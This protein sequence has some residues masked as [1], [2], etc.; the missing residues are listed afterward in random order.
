MS[1]PLKPCPSCGAPERQLLPPVQPDPGYTLLTAG[2][3]ICLEACPSCGTLWC[4]SPYE[5]Y[6]S[7]SYRVRWP[8]SAATWKQAH[9][10]DN[11][12]TLRHW[13][14]TEI[15]RLW[16]KLD[17]AGKQAVENHRQR[18]GGHNPIDGIYTGPAPDL[19]LVLGP[20]PKEQN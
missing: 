13:H 11:G 8:W 15:R 9:D 16:Q 6:L 14:I 19:K 2:N 1:N 3:Y 12:E 4:E 5:P 17:P 7:F 20:P 10:R 18:A